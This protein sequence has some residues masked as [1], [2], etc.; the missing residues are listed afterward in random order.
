MLRIPNNEYYTSIIIIFIIKRSL[1]QSLLHS[2]CDMFNIAINISIGAEI[3]NKLNAL[4]GNR[5]GC[6]L[7]S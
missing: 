3:S 2:K 6:R 5:S 7:G 4:R 1:K